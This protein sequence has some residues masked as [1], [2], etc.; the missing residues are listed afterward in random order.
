MDSRAARSA[1]DA[2]LGY[3]PQTRPLYQ[4]TNQTAVVIVE[5]MYSLVH[6]TI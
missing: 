4:I 5:L 2:R 6:V 3:A 1:R